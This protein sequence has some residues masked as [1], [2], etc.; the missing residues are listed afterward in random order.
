MAKEGHTLII[1]AR[2]AMENAIAA[3]RT[4][5]RSDSAQAW[6]RIAAELRAGETRQPAAEA[7]GDRLTLHDVEGEIC[8]A[9]RVIVR[10]RGSDGWWLHTDDRVNCDHI[11]APDAYSASEPPTTRM[12]L[13]GELTTQ[14]HVPLRQQPDSGQ[15]QAL[16]GDCIH[17]GYSVYLDATDGAYRHDVNG[18]R[19]CPTPQQN[20]AGD[21][22]FVHT[23]AWPA[24]TR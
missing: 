1:S 10:R 15:P 5:G 23:M 22:T 14:L 12:D 18:Q 21:E 24:V 13:R 8:P 6:V 16:G 3:A 20:A 9:G 17:C 2:E 7:P 11:E 19:T 4:S